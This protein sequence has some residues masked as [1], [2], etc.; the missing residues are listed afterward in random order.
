MEGTGLLLAHRLVAPLC[1]RRNPVGLILL[2]RRALWRT[3]LNE[4][5]QRYAGSTIGLFWVA[6]AP[7]C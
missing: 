1:S 3:T 2:Y 4:V 5:R 7:G 6:L